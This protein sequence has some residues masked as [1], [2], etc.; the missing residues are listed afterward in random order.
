MWPAAAGVG[1][2]GAAVVGVAVARWAGAPVSA[3]VSLIKPCHP[4]RRKT[5]T[6]FVAAPAL[7]LWQHALLQA[8]R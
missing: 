1:V 4:S 8:Q 6:R 7:S 5:A 2:V 3:L